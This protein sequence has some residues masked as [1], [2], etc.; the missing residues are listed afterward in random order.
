MGGRATEGPGPYGGQAGWGDDALRVR[1]GLLM[2]RLVRY[3]GGIVER[4]HGEEQDF[5]SDAMDDGKMGSWC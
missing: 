5:I 2:R 3:G 4:F 1:L